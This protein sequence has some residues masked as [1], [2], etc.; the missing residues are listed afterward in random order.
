MFCYL[1]PSVLGQKDWEVLSHAHLRRCLNLDHYH[2]YLGLRIDTSEW[3]RVGL[4]GD[5]TK[6]S[7]LAG[8]DWVGCVFLW[9]HWSC[10]P[11]AWGDSEA[12]DVLSH[13]S[14]CSADRYDPV[15]QLRRVLPLH[16]WWGSEVTPDHSKPTTGSC[17]ANYQNHVLH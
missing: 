6:H 15:R 8:Y 7:H 3:Q 4:G 11:L 16:L 2:S 9:G 13:P 10:P 1:C 14:L 5:G 17:C 12:R